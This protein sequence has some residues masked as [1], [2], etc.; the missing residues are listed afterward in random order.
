MVYSQQHRMIDVAWITRPVDGKR[1]HATA[2]RHLTQCGRR[3]DRTWSRA[4][5]QADKVTCKIC[6]RLIS[7]EPRDDHA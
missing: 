2:G 5:G 7:K 6:S 3:L 1:I 4:V